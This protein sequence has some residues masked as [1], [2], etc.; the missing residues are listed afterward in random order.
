MDGGVAQIDAD[1]ALDGVD[2]AATRTVAPRR[3][4]GPASAGRS[5][6]GGAGYVGYL[7]RLLPVTLVPFRLPWRNQ[8]RCRRVG[9]ADCCAR[10]GW[11]TR[12]CGAAELETQMTFESR[13]YG[14]GG[15]GV[16]FVR[17]RGCG[18]V[19]RRDERAGKRGR[20]HLPVPCASARTLR[21]DPAACPPCPSCRFH[22]RRRRLLLL[23]L[24][25]STNSLMMFHPAASSR[26]FSSSRLD[27]F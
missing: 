16:V 12:R 7:L 15:C 25:L 3:T 11:P 18:I 24:V 14:G 20:V 17:L 6:V 23:L 26:C 27:C 21:V 10:L 4:T 19:V 5:L 1:G 2:G 9:A 8:E 13:L 22:P